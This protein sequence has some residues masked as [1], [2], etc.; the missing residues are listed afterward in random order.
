MTVRVPEGMQAAIGSR[1]FGNK[2]HIVATGTAGPPGF[3]ARR[4]VAAYVL[5]SRGLTLYCF[6]SLFHRADRQHACCG[7][8][9]LVS[10]LGYL[11][12]DRELCGKTAQRVPRRA[13]RDVSMLE[14]SAE[15]L[16]L[17][18]EQALK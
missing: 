15:L 8:D 7:F 18:R 3:S 14:M 12:G 5:T 4:G 6:F 1:K 17:Q 11:N 2:Q 10:M 16:T 13:G 9:P